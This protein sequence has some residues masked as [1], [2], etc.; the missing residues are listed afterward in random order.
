MSENNYVTSDMYLSAFLLSQGFVLEDI[1]RSD[2]KRLG[3]VFQDRPDRPQLV[4]N[5]LSGKAIV[6]VA[7]FIYQL[8]RAKRLLYADRNDE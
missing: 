8:R 7:D 4:H 2:G 5:F 1:D 3:F 6:N